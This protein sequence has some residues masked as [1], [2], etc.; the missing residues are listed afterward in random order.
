MKRMIFAAMATS[1]LIPIAAIAAPTDF[2][3]TW[4]VD[5]TTMKMTG[6]PLTM[7]VQ[8][9][10][11]DCSSCVPKISIKADGQPQAIT[12]NPATDQ[13]AVD[14][15]DDRHVSITRFK[16][17]K[18]VGTVSWAVA[19]DGKLATEEF[20][21][22][23]RTGSNVSGKYVFRRVGEGPKGANSASGS[24]LPNT[25]NESE[26]DLMETI[27]GDGK[28]ITIKQ[29]T[30]VRVTAALGGSPSPVEG[31]VGNTTATYKISGSQLAEQV[32]RDGKLVRNATYTLNKD[33]KTIDVHS[34]NPVVDHHVSYMLVRQ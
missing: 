4:K 21:S 16:D 20:S 18:K 34:E 28:Q 3:G 15:K 24:W 5:V 14:V 17:G 13:E 31:A 2:N 11:Y 23:L 27:S 22:T 8:N 32:W 9:G 12:G 25:L 29:G 10:M 1:F 19:P 6:K 26:N 33:G 7:V 30:G